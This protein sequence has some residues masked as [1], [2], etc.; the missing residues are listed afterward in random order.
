MKV[1]QLIGLVVIFAMAA[2]T[3]KQGASGEATT[4]SGLDRNYFQSVV[5]GDSTDLYVL[6]NGDGYDHNW[7]LNTG[8]DILSLIHI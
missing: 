7:V 2:C 3:G 5:N 6:K 1:K 8:G 4:L